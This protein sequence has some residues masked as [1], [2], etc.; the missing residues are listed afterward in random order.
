MGDNLRVA[1]RAEEDRASV[2]I[3]AYRV[4]D[5]RRSIEELFEIYGRL[6]NHIVRRYSGRSNEPYQDLLQIGYVGFLKAVKD[7]EFGSGA[8]FGSYAYSK[9][10]GELRHHFRDNSLLRKPRWAKS[11]YSKV[12]AA[13]D[14]LTG[15]LG[16]PPLIEEIACEVNVMPEGI[17]ELMKLFL[18]TDVSS[19]DE[20]RGSGEGADVAAIKNIQYEAFS[21]PIE[22]RIHLEQAVQSLSELQQKVVY[23]FFY[24]D[25]SQTEIGKRLGLPQRKISRI[26]ASAVKSLRAKVSNDE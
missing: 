11:L 13:T 22:D 21:L 14:R 18:D 8:R 25:L 26:I 2:L 20:E 1:S 15:E 3:E 7:Y 19:L 17:L 9:I 6:L 5:D 24:K 16:R 12:S 10:D 4:R 23:L